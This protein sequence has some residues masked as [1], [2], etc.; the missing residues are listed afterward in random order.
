VYI[1]S[2]AGALCSLMN[3]LTMSWALVSLVVPLVSGNDN[4]TENFLRGTNRTCTEQLTHNAARDPPFYM[5][6]V[7]SGTVVVVC[8]Y[9]FPQTPNP[10]ALHSWPLIVLT[11]VST[12]YQCVRDV[13]AA[14]FQYMQGTLTFLSGPLLTYAFVERYSPKGGNC[15]R[16]VC[17]G[18]I[19]G[20]IGT[21][22]GIAVTLIVPFAYAE[23]THGQLLYIDNCGSLRWIRG[24][25]QLPKILQAYLIRL[26][27]DRLPWSKQVSALPFIIAS[28]IYVPPVAVTGITHILFGAV[29]Y[30]PLTLVLLLTMFCFFVRLEWKLFSVRGTTDQHSAMAMLQDAGQIEHCSECNGTGRKDLGGLFKSNCEACG[31][32]GKV[33]QAVHYGCTFCAGKSVVQNQG[34]VK[35]STCGG[36]GKKACNQCGGESTVGF[37]SRLGLGSWARKCTECNGAGHLLCADCNGAGEVA[38]TVVTPCPQCSG[39]GTYQGPMLNIRLEIK[40]LLVILVIYWQFVGEAMVRT[41]DGEKWMSALHET[42]EARSAN[43]YFVY[44]KSRFDEI[45]TY[46]QFF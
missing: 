17:L 24:A 42:W 9:A 22:L 44:L 12:L 29:Y 40:L 15:I 5:Q 36:S 8:H 7:Q 11:T 30:L 3:R 35:C 31:G 1:L 38:G 23:V 37:R 45:G 4:L 20:L 10:V 21:A 33:L 46:M 27:W 14:P 41:Y 43:S 25:G 19:I 32:S 18:I 39:T 28:A 34:M 26:G 2:F 6:A 16:Q 13:L